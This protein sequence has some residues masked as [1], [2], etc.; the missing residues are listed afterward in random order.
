MSAGL[1]KVHTGWNG[2]GC[3]G[4]DD[5]GFLCMKDHG[6]GGEAVKVDEGRGGR[7]LEPN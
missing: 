3:Q 6:L 2:E 4:G 5:E 7:G 1:V